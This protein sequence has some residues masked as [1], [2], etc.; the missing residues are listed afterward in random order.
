MPSHFIFESSV[1]SV[2]PSEDLVLAVDGSHKDRTHSSAYITDSGL[3]GVNAVN[4]DPDLCRPQCALSTELRAALYGL[5]RVGDQKVTLLSD[6]ESTIDWINRWKEG[7]DELPAWYS[8]YRS[9][10]KASLLELRDLV[11]ARETELTIVKVKAHSGDLL[12]EAADSLARI[13]TNV[14]KGVYEKKGAD[15]RAHDLAQAF[16]RAYEVA[17]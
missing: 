4:F 7:D 2:S 17:S 16:L 11:T 14:I 6:N 5:R 13:G 10:G 12:N 8:L 1:A 15:Q 3:F 9:R